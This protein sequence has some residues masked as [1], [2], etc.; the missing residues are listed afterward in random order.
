MNPL[1]LPRPE[2]FT[3]SAPTNGGT[4]IAYLNGS[5][6]PSARRISPGA[7]SSIATS[8]MPW[9]PWCLKNMPSSFARAGQAADPE[10]ARER[11]GAH[12]G[13][14]HLQLLL[15]QVVAGVEDELVGGPETGRALGGGDHHR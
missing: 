8:K 9:M 14:R 2:A 4:T 15:A 6:R 1:G 12:V 10:V 3:T 7:T 11:L 13:D 5:L